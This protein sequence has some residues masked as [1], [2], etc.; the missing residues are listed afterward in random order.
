MVMDW[1]AFNNAASNAILKA[2]RL[3]ELL[4][5]LGLDIEIFAGTLTYRTS[6]PI[7]GG[8]G[9][10]FVLCLEGDTLPVYWQCF[11]QH[12]EKKYK[13]SLLGLVRGLLY[14][15]EFKDVSLGE[16]VQYL[17]DFLGDTPSANLP[18]LPKP[19]R[20]KG[21]L[22]NLTREQVRG[23]LEIPSPYFV[24]R[25][26]SPA[27]L[28]ALDVGHSVRRRRTI[29][30]VYDDLGRTC[31]GFL[32]RSEKPLCGVCRR[33]HHPRSE[34]RYGQ[35]RWGV[36][37]GFTKQQFLYNYAHARR[38]EHPFVLLVEGPG[39]V[40]RATEAGFPA[41][42]L[43][44]TDMSEVQVEKLAAM[45]SE[46]VIAFDNDEPGRE[47]GQRVYSRLRARSIDVG[48][49]SPPE[50]FKDVGEMPPEEVVAW[51]ARLKEQQDLLDEVLSGRA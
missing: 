2:E 24:S 35:A 15:R 32:E 38:S 8:D 28:D 39:E 43:L 27:V 3:G 1:N 10:G 41:V 19:A 21:K 36:S 7:H 23:R 18:W 40:F 49:W 17:K 9:D 25:G 44:G 14:A 29:V 11:S 51:L 33:C 48:I 13:P 6:C 46:V 42:G 22:L 20:P 45:G 34:C 5:G 30:P 47:N 16:A 12:C 50:Q 37:R 4:S 26:F 31:V